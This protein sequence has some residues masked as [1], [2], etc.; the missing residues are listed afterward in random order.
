MLK[1]NITKR[2]YLDNTATTRTRRQVVVTINRYLCREY[3]NP[4]AIH[5]SGLVA[6]GSMEMARERIAHV[7]SCASEELV[8]TGSGSESNNLAV[9]GAVAALKGRHVITS[10]IEHSSV[11]HTCRA[12]EEQ[13]VAVTYLD[14]DRQ[15]R[16]NLAALAQQLRPETALVSLMWVNNEIGTVQDIQAIVEIVKSRGVLLHIDAVQ[17]LPYL[18]IN[19]ETLG[20]D[21]VSFSGHKLYAPKG[22]GLLYVRRGTPVQPIL[23]G[24]GQEFDLRSGTENVPYIVGLSRA[25]VLNH[26]EKARYVRQLLTS[27]DRIIRE[28][29][30]RIPGVL[31]TG[32]PVH[33]SPNHASFCFQGLSGKM[34]VK[35]LAYYGLEVSSGS[36]CS[37]P[38]NDPSHV[39]AACGIPQDYLFGSLRIT[40]GRYNTRRDVDYL[41]QVLPRVVQ[42][43]RRAPRAYQNETAFI[44]QAEFAAKLAAGERLQILDVRSPKIPSGEIPGAIC[45]PNWR[46]KAGLHR[47]DP[48]QE[49]VVVC[50]QGDV[51]SP[52]VQQLLTQRGFTNVRVLKGGYFNYA[53][54]H[55]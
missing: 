5:R 55:P 53:G 23:T 28:V 31:L 38:R 34:L 45:I 11:L 9:R 18:E 54:F 19:L 46:L 3:A 2:V 32:D 43:M 39:L 10:Q 17:A 8:F 15:G 22:V 12:L 41:L 1:P 29:L 7:L 21:L 50:Y 47:L 6:R 35:E 51:L 16:F 4:S 27:R 49:T 13:G 37:S 42:Q 33:R 20:A 36:A 52:Q 25:I 48:T 26:K 14:V 30:A 44:S 40:L 24:G